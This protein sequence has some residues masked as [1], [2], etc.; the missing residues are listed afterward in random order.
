MENRNI[1]ALL[2]GVGDYEQMN[3]A[4]L[5]T[6]KLDL[7]L[8][9]SSLMSGL[10][11]PHDSLR[12]LSGNDNSG[13]VTTSDL[14]H[15]IAD[16]R[17]LLGSEDTFILYFSGHGR[18]NNLIFSNGQVELQSVIDFI[19]KLPS[20]NKIVLL[21]C[22]YSGNF[23]SNGARIMGFDSYMDEFAGRG[24]AVLASSSANEVSRLGPSRN[25]SMFT[26]ALSTALI[27][28][29]RVKKGQITLKDIYDETMLLVNAWNKENPGKEQQPIFRRSVGG[30]I[31]FTVDDYHPYEQ[32]ELSRDMGAYKIVK[33]EPLSAKNIKRLCAFVIIDKDTS[34]ENLSHITKE[35]VE[36][37]K[38]AEIYS[39]AK[40]EAA[41]AG[42]PAKA[43]WCYFGFDESDIINHLHAFYT[44]RAETKELKDLYYREHKDAKVIDD[45]YVYENTSYRMLKKMQESTQTREEFVEDNRRLLAV[46]VN[47][48]EEF[49]SDLQEVKNKT[50]C[51]EEMQSKYGEWINSVKRKYLE[52]TDGDI[53][54][55]DLHD[56]SEEI[57]SLAGWILDLSIYIRKEN[58]DDS[59]D[60]REKWLINNAISKYYES[61]EKIKII[62][63]TIQW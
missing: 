6:Y 7:A 62:E 36:E 22:C 27:S 41:F 46:I 47:L 43:V 48:A 45:I 38:Y 14:A 18:S 26:G 32:M 16:F 53:A 23:A 60:D 20:K 8:I 49:I 55:D 31:F 59:V 10:K 5:P 21:D 44:I 50:L 35:I 42:T 15:A 24:I 25:H 13:Y 37:I 11:V 4:N 19:E 34:K 58:P 52:L 9:G 63:D 12:I 29:N 33:V 2:I 51:I 1:F 56:W 61:I 30:T 39:T 17:S 54:P 28:K 57:L 3:I 40:S